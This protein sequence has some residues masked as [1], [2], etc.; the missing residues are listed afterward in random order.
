MLKRLKTVSMMLFLMGASTGAAFAVP[1]NGADDV[2]ITQ[3]SETATGTV[4]DAMGPVIGASVVVKGTT[5]GTITDFDGNFSIPGVKKGDILEISFVG[6]KT[7]E[8]VWNG[9]ALNVTMEDDTQQ[10]AEVVVTALGMKRETKALGYAVTEMKGDELSTAVVNPVAAL[11]GKVAGVEIAQSDGGIFGSAKIQIRGNSTLGSNNQPIYVVDGV[12][13]DNSTQGADVDGET[14]N[15]N[16]YGNELKNL[17]PDDFETVSVLKGAAATALYGS[18][19]L[20]GAV[21]ITTKG[22]GKSKGF[23]IDV[24]QTLGIDKMY[25]APGIQTEYGLGARPG[26]IGYAADGNMWI[27]TFKLNSN[28][29]P[30]V[31]GTGSGLGWGPKYDSSIMIEDFDGRM[32]PYAP[33]KDNMLD[34]YQTGFNTNTNVAIRGGNETTS[35][36][37]SVSYKNV[38]ST[39][40]NNTFERYSVLLKGSHKISDRV[41][42]AASVSFANSKPRNAQRG[43]GEH[44]Y[45][46]SYMSPL[47]DAKYFRDKYLSEDGGIARTGD[48]YANVPS[49]AKS[50]WFTTDW[51]DYVRKETVVRPTMEVNVKIA[52]WVRFKAEGNMNYVYIKEESKNWGSGV[53]FEGGGYSLAQSTKEQTTFAGTFTF[54]KEVKDFTLGGFVRGE[55]YTTAEQYLSVSTRDGLIVPGQFF[56]N[57]SKGTPT[58]GNQAKGEIRGTKRMLSAVGAFNASWKNQLFLDVTGRNDWSSSLVYSNGTGNHSYFYPSVSGSWILTETFRDDMPEWISFAKLRASWAQVGSDTGAYTVNSGYSVGSLQTSNG[59]VYMNSFSGTAIATD[60]KPERKNSWEVGMDLRF[61]NNRIHLDATYYKENTTDQIMHVSTPSISGVSSKL[62]NA[63]DI[64]NSGIEI[65]LNTVP[66]RNKDWEWNL[67]FTFTKNSNKII[68]L[69]P[70]A[71]EYIGL[72]GSTGWGDIRIQS[73]AKIGGPYGM[74]IS[75]ITPKRDKQGNVILK[76]SDSDRSAYADRSG[77]NE[78]IGDIN[79]DFLGSVST[80]LTWKNLTFRMAVDMRFGG[81]IASYANRYGTAYGWT[82]E[83]LKYR[84]EAH[85][86]ITWTSQYLN[87]DGTPSGS[88][89]YTYHDGIIPQGI[90]AEGTNVTGVDGK[91]HNVGGMSYEAAVK[92]GILEPMHAASYYNYA[93]QWST[94]VVNDTWVNELNYVALRE[95]SLGYNFSSKI[96]G[97]IGAKKLGVTLSARNLGYLYNS[98]PNNLN[99]ESVRGNKSGEF[100]SRTFDPLCANYTMTINVGF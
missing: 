17:T 39:T 26:R 97:K 87:A 81:M 32:I 56:I 1:A 89:G 36:Y 71:A 62:I 99:P 47:F 53:A 42:I 84:D 21:V 59:N 93:N 50:Y 94:G 51:N 22:G 27:P 10:L 58:Y 64:Q 63:G 79:P 96:A 82:E 91:Q 20:N 52:D 92:A 15:A 48:Q 3:Q 6:Y 88:Y 60:L 68:D 61:L 85:G 80:G 73:V 83:S 2:K 14:V 23:G 100:R 7:Q 41:D 57:N 86:G 98:L 24:T 4:V 46:Q 67:D 9:T 74:L 43:V 49:A 72:Q 13:L 34:M 37:S 16:D 25:G 78:V 30:T 40:E 44:F 54:N 18:R 31:I 35:F 12:I 95:I 29:V 69:H 8:I 75:D 65:A 33:I 38:K 28:G 19:G 77:T 66:F 5:N 45:R 11:Q 55:Y 70:D 76:W 90:F